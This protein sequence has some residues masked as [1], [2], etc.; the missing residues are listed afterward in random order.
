[1]IVSTRSVQL[2]KQVVLWPTGLGVRLQNVRSGF[3]PH[4]H[5]NASSKEQTGLPKPGIRVRFPVGAHLP[6][7]R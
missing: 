3:D 5:L 1:M 7:L 4:Q 2:N 6:V